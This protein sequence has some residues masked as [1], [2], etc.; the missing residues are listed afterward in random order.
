MK[1][2]HICNMYFLVHCMIFILNIIENL[3]WSIAILHANTLSLKSQLLSMLLVS[4]AAIFRLVGAL[5]NKHLW[6]SSDEVVPF[7]WTIWLPGKTPQEAFYLSAL[8]QIDVLHSDS[9]FFMYKI[10]LAWPSCS[11]QYIIK[12][13]K[14]TSR[15]KSELSISFLIISSQLFLISHLMSYT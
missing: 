4:T 15:K 2:L 7:H 13:K 8:C 14:Q 9:W 5:F 1:N 10:C 3:Q 12:G 6:D 11:H